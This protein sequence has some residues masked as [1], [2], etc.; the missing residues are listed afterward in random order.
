MRNINR[1]LTL[2]NINDRAQR[3]TED[4]RLIW[5][6]FEGAFFVAHKEDRARC[7]KVTAEKC[8][9][10][11]AAH[12]GTCKH[13]LGLPALIE[14]EIK[15]YTLLGFKA[16]RERMETFRDALENAQEWRNAAHV[17]EMAERHCCSY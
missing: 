16:D 2:A 8:D 7:Y 15:R 14:V 10:P 17:D 1:A 13:Y 6:R 4:Y 3:I 11:A 12:Y 9:C 5:N